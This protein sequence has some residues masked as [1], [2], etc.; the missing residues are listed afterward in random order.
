MY[1]LL[2]EISC[3]VSAMDM[4]Q[5]PHGV[6]F[7]FGDGNGTVQLVGVG[8]DNS[9]FLSD[10]HHFYGPISSLKFFLMGM[11]AVWVVLLMS[12]VPCL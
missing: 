7:V 6:M 5:L 1:F 4:L 2:I 8:K 11:Q 10:E 12:L 9:L 3:R